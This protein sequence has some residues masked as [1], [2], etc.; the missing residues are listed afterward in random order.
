M[1]YYLNRITLDLKSCLFHFCN[2]H[3]GIY[4]WVSDSQNNS[5]YNGHGK[6]EGFKPSA[7]RYLHC[8][9]LFV[10]HRNTE[11]LLL[12]VSLFSTLILRSSV[13]F[14]P[15]WVLPTWHL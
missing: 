1:V 9:Y 15:S 2:Q 5:M 3:Q 12:T 6:Q 8:P 10:N 11:V 13:D 4:K 7:S 14:V